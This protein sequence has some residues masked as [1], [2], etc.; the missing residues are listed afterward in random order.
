MAP[1]RNRAKQAARRAPRE[2]A[3]RFDAMGAFESFPAHIQAAV[4]PVDLHYQVQGHSRQRALEMAIVETLEHFPDYV[5]D[6]LAQEAQENPAR[7][8]EAMRA[9]RLPP[10]VDADQVVEDLATRLPPQQPPQQPTQPQVQPFSGSCHRLGEVDL[11][12]MD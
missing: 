11:Q 7:M 3:T 5:E 1:K 9:T 8:A 4:R 2:G 12:G 6:R 10:G